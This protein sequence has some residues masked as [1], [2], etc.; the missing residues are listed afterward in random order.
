MNWTNI[1]TYSI[2]LIVSGLFWWAI[3]KRIVEVL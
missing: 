3:I 1:I 2:I